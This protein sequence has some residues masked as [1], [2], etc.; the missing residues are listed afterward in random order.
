MNLLPVAQK[1]QD[2][3]LGVMGKT[4]FIN[5]IPAEAPRGLLLRNDLRGTDIDYELPGYY[6]TMFQLIARGASYADTEAL[7]KS[8]ITALTIKT[9]TA[10]GTMRFS[11][12]RPDRLPVVYPLSKGSLLEYAVNM[13]CCFTE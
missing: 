10:L 5:M 12:L 1:L 4:I 6:R 2:A 3:S 8:A 7:L 9:P 11:Y 13:E